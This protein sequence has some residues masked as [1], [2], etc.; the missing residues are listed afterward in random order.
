MGY[1]VASSWNAQRESQVSCRK[2][3]LMT[4]VL[5]NNGESIYPVLGY[6]YGPDGKYDKPRQIKTE[7]Q[8]RQ[9]FNDVVKPAL[10]EKREIRITNM[11]DEILFHVK[12]GKVLFDGKT[13]VEE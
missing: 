6:E 8:L 13:V 10:K 12:N 3:Y 9:F 1:R 7:G 5:P 4:R 11:S 2:E